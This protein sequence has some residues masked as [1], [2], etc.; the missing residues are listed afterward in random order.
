MSLQ[1]YTNAVSVKGFVAVSAEL[2][3]YIATAF[4]KS[5]GFSESFL[6]FVD[7]VNL[8]QCYD[9]DFTSFC[10]CP[11]RSA[12]GLSLCTVRTK[13]LHS[14]TLT[15]FVAEAQLINTIFHI[16]TGRCY[17]CTK[18]SDKTQISDTEDLDARL[19][20]LHY[21]KGGI[22]PQSMKEDL[23]LYDII[24]NDKLKDHYITITD[25]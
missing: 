20:C 5:M 17:A 11:F 9:I 12:P 1:C 10:T 7:K 18:L 23:L 24:H 15:D 14:K 25:Y 22:K 8:C 16:K 4:L 21:V 2:G 3:I 13:L 6:D 19:F